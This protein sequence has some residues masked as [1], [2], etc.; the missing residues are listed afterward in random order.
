MKF[1]NYNGCREHPR[2]YTKISNI[3]NLRFTIYTVTKYVVTISHKV[4]NQLLKLPDKPGVY[5]LKDED[6]NVIFINMATSL[7]KQ[8]RSHFHSN[9]KQDL[10]IKSKTRNIELVE[11]EDE[12]AAVKLE[13]NLKKLH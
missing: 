8:I 10:I 1:V 7:S 13:L 4:L 6:D 11:E 9:K 3:K 5:L 12:F 2:E